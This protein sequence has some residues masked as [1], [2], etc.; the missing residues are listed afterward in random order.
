MYRARVRTLVLTIKGWACRVLICHQQKRS[1]G[2]WRTSSRDFAYFCVS[3]DILL[4]S[5][6][7]RSSP[8]VPTT[9]VIR[10]Q[11]IQTFTLQGRHRRFVGDSAFHTS[12]CG[13]PFLVGEQQKWYHQILQK[14]QSLMSHDY[15]VLYI[16]LYSSMICTS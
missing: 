14:I 10:K 4:R 3:C 15:N 2:G 8:C 13:A 1:F 16:L 9:V 7:K 6:W 12:L 11:P 5:Q